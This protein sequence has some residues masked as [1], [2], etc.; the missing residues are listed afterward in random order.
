MTGLLASTATPGEARTALDG[1]AD[2]IDLKDPARGALGA[3]GLHVQCAVVNMVA[4]RRTVSATVGDLPMEPGVLAHAIGLTAG[5]GVDLVKVGLPRLERHPRCLAAL[6]R[7]ARD[8]ARIV[9]VLFAELAPPVWLVDELAQ[10]GCH[11]VMLDTGNKTS[12]N[13]CCYADPSLLAD[14]VQRARRNGL[15]SGLAGSL[16]ACD[17]PSLLA[18]EPDYLGFRGALCAQG[19]RTAGLSAEALGRIRRLLPA[20][21][22]HADSVRPQ[23][24]PPAGPETGA[25]I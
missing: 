9:A 2:I 10:A 14:F 13:L 25:R 22:A 19:L 15:L 11:G 21:N 7:A 16:A 20:D 12:G 3:V 8:G 18:L 23:H 17:I 24:A 6:D 5:S 1:G 4:G